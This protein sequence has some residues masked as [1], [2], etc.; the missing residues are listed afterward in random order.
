G[1]R[2][3]PLTEDDATIPLFHNDRW[4][5]VRLRDT[6]H[7]VEREY[8]D[9]DGNRRAVL[10]LPAEVPPSSSLTVSVTYEIEST[11]RQRPE[12]IPADAG[13]F[14]EIPPGLLEEFT[15]ETE[16][17]TSGD[18]EVR[19]LALRLAADETTV[20]GAVT[21]LLDWIM[22]EISY[23]NFEVPRYPGETLAGGEGDCDDQALLLIAMCRALGIPSFLQVGV[24]FSGAIE[25]ERTSWG[26]HL[27]IKQRGVGWH[28]WAMVY[29]PPWGWLPIDLTIQKSR[30]PF[31]LIAE[32]PEYKGQFV[33]A[34]NISRQAYIGD[35]RRSR[36]ELMSSGL[37]IT[38]SEMWVRSGSADRRTTLILV[39]LG[40]SVS[41]A[42]V[43]AIILRGR[44]PFQ[45]NRGYS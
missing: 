1:D 14:S 30:D 12:I 40:V 43:V 2:A 6:T 45:K 11:D 33:T 44:R 36:E 32:A 13:S 42:L 10:H 35:S 19:T 28:G 4:Q 22:A 17:F 8:L 16:T 7:A 3:H 29:I 5:T 25:S 34:M 39:V 31:R 27:R 9:V 38:V 37:H 18:E 41:S 26:G 15:A 21:R 24:V 23:R 20:L